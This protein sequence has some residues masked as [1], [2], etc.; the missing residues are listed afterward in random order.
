MS[1]STHKSLGETWNSNIP[2][3]VEVDTQSVRTQEKQEAFRHLKGKEAC[4]KQIH[5]PQYQ[6]NYAWSFI[7]KCSGV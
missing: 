4:A 7:F 3:H 6:M 5:I 2:Y 1:I